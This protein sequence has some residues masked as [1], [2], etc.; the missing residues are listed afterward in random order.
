MN[1]LNVIRSPILLVIK[2]GNVALAQLWI[3]WQQQ[4]NP[5]PFHEF[6]LIHQPLSVSVAG[7]D[8]SLGRPL[9]SV[10]DP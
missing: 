4:H 2:A 10:Q 5:L 1:E 7:W 9:E 8:E 6:V 3:T